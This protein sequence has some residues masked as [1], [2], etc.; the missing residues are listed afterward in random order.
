MER[1]VALVVPRD[2]SPSSFEE[3]RGR[4]RSS[5]EFGSVWERLLL[6]CHEDPTGCDVAALLA[7]AGDERTLCEGLE[8][9]DARAPRRCGV[10]MRERSGEWLWCSAERV[11]SP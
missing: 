9:L 11:G 4:V 1:A 8:V 2:F 5:P 10:C 3:W 7:I 6:R